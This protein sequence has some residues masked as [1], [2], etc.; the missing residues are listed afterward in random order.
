[1]G[2]TIGF[3]YVALKMLADSMHID[4]SEAIWKKVRAV[5][6]VIRRIEAK[7]RKNDEAQRNNRR[8]HTIAPRRR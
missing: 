7:E 5:E 1:M 6:N 3:D 2:G 4:I 8:N